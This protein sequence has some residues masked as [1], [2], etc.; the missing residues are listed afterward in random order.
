MAH[1]H[2]YTRPTFDE[3]LRAWQGLLKERGFPIDLIW[4]FDENL[5]FE[6][7]AAAPGQRKQASSQQPE[8]QNGFRPHDEPG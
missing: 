2:S 7:D 8:K 6:R 3:A 1:T 4:A 5:C